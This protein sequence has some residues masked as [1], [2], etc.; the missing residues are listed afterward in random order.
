[1]TSNRKGRR[2]KPAPRGHWRDGINDEDK[3]ELQEAVAIAL[4]REDPLSLLVLVSYFMSVYDPRPTA[5]CDR[6]EESARTAAARD[7]LLNS[8]VVSRSSEVSVLL[9]VWAEFLDDGDTSAA[10]IRAELTSRPP[11]TPRWLSRVGQTRIH[12]AVRVGYSLSGMDCLLLE[13]RVPARGGDFTCAV[14][15]DADG[16][17][18]V[19]DCFFVEGAV[20]ELV[21]EIESPSREIHCDEITLADVRARLEAAIAHEY[22]LPPHRTQ[23]WPGL[24][25]LV[26][27]LLRGLPEGGS[28]DPRPELDDFDEFGL[29]RRFLASALG[30]PF[31]R[32]EERVAS[33]I[34]FGL[35]HG[36]G[37]PMRWS[38]RRAER[39]LF[40]EVLTD[41]PYDF[42]GATEDAPSV[43]KAFIRFVHHE[44][45]VSADFTEGLLREIEDREPEFQ[46]MLDDLRDDDE[47]GFDPAVGD[48]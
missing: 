29:T 12:R 23:T 10:A 42:L 15:L 40:D 9:A 19:L 17:D 47:W 20:D 46:M 24:R 41:S 26:E 4:A 35:E 25:A 44:V 38:R 32:Q 28:P 27:W 7:E 6:P 13:G 30:S 37:D 1:M 11:L 36:T 18:M 3:S 22:V 34:G 31:T 8:L 45:G 33:L 21:A 5:L 48:G 39:W 43:L 2:G 14:C 16:L